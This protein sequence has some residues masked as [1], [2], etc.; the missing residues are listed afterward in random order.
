MSMYGTG[1]RTPVVAC[2][3][4]EDRTKQEFKEE[5]DV[6]N[7]MAKFAKTGMITHLAKGI[8]HFSDV[9]EMGDYRAAIENVRAADEYF[10]QLPAK[11]RAHF[12]HDAANF[13]EFSQKPGA[14][15][16]LRELGLQEYARGGDRRATEVPPEVPEVVPA[17]PVKED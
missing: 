13:L 12:D 1:T 7:I 15:E 11:L 16:E 6:N 10:Q 17:E 5:C 14:V 3:P 2:D 9:S 8:P 4:E